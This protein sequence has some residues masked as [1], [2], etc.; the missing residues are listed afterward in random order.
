[1]P[2][3]CVS[4]AESGALVKMETIMDTVAPNK[5]FLAGVL[6]ANV[7]Q[8]KIKKNDNNPKLKSTNVLI[9]VIQ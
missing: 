9:W 2:L 4:L 6:K 3:G 5:F 1:M 7:G 8:M